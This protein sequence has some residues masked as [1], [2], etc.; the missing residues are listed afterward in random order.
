[1]FNEG[2]DVIIVDDIAF[3]ILKKVIKENFEPLTNI[4]TGRNPFGIIGKESYLNKIAQ[5]FNDGTLFEL[6]CKADTIKWIKEESVTKNLNIFNNYKVF[7]SK[8]AGNPNSDLKVI[9]QPYIGKPKTACTDSLFTIGNFDN[10]TET[11]NLQKYIKTKFLRY[12]VS[13]LKISQNVTQIVY[14]YVPMQNFTNSSDIDW[15]KTIP[16]IDQQLY[17]KYNLTEE[18]INFIE[19]KIKPME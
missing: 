14:A 12:L 15:S 5:N 16:E 13:I 18:E 8:S 1:M 4:T 6:R 19:S 17:K 3:P 7:I 9:G 11:I 2:L 10:L